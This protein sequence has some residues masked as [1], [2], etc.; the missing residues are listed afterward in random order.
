MK[1]N[2]RTLAVCILIPLL[3]GAVAGLFTGNGM[4]EFGS[5]NQPPLTPPAWIFPIVWA[6][7]YILMGTG[8]FLIYQQKN[9]EEKKNKALT[10]YFYQLLVNFLW[11]VFFFSFQWYFFSFI[12]LGLL[13]ILAAKMILEFGNINKLA[14]YLNI[15]YLLWLSFAGYLNLGVWLLN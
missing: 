5:M 10:T 4:S 13:W 11:P 8:S 2:W 9:E 12:W 14:A 6:I 1:K 3:T 7:L 15:P